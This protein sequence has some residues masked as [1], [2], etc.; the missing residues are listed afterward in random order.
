MVFGE[1]FLGQKP[2]CLNH[3]VCPVGD[4]DPSTGGRGAG[5]P[6][7]LS[8]RLRQTSRRNKKPLAHSIREIPDH[9]TFREKENTLGWLDKL[10][11]FLSLT[12]CN[13]ANFDQLCLP[14]Y[15]CYN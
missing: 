4:E 1:P 13:L 8:E 14:K 9:A 3:G 5:L 12:L 10:R 15:K 11:G 2:C 7:G 6:Q